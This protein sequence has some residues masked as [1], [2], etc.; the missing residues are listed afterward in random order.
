[1]ASDNKECYERGLQLEKD[2]NSIQEAVSEHHIKR[3][4]I[5]RFFRTMVLQGIIHFLSIVKI[6]EILYNEVTLF[7]INCYLM[8]LSGKACQRAAKLNEWTKS[9]NVLYTQ[10]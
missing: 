4:H 10:N 9:M 3:A 6:L 5:L 2:C 1:M 7:A 8:S